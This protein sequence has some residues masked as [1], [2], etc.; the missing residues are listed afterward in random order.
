M[1]STLI[2][3]DRL[4]WSLAAV[5]IIVLAFLLVKLRGTAQHA[6]TREQI[7]KLGARA[8]F[9]KSDIARR[10]CDALAAAGCHAI[11]V[12]PISTTYGG[13]DVVKMSPSAQGFAAPQIMNLLDGFD[14][15]SWG[16][17]TVGY[18]H[19]IKTRAPSAVVV[20]VA[21]RYFPENL[22][23]IHRAGEGVSCGG[24]KPTGT[25]LAVEV[26]AADEAIETDNPRLLMAL[27]PADKHSELRRRFDKAWG[28]TQ[29]DVNDLAA[30]RAY[31]AAYVSL[32]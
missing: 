10:V 13:H 7:A 19:H 25:V 31:V 5:P 32:L 26:V 17:G 14:V 11:R 18:C 9:Y 1:G 27:I 22:M 16:D 28:L 20:G 29:F 30:G 23:R 3:I 4:H 12:K 24:I 15:A 8:G 6:G 2:P 21:D